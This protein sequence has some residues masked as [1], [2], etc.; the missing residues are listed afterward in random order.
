MVS[1]CTDAWPRRC[2]PLPAFAAAAL[3]AG[4]VGMGGELGGAERTDDLPCHETPLCYVASH[5]EKDPERLVLYDL[6]LVDTT[7][8]ISR[9]KADRAE[10]NG[11]DFGTSGWVL[12]GHV[13]MFIPEGE[14]RADRAT[15]KFASGRID[16]MTAEGAPA[17]FEHGL[18]NGQTAHGHAH[19]IRFDMT[20][21]EL[22]LDGD[23]WLSDGCNEITSGHISY[24]I[25]S[26][27][28]HADSAPGDGGR[29]HG[30][31]RSSAAPNQCTPAAGRP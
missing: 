6:D 4:P 5:A 31:I 13:Q 7:R 14:L 12:T 20:H 23:S 18:D 30:T 9:L 16:S 24:D 8:G 11:R 21:N 26:Q 1:C 22:Q 29:V 27:R 17:E 3:L 25:G 28:M 2:L 10:G 15:V 19:A